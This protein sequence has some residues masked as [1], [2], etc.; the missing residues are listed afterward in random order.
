[1]GVQNRFWFAELPPQLCTTSTF[2]LF[3]P[4]HFFWF[5]LLFLPLIELFARWKTKATAVVWVFLI[6][7]EKTCLKLFSAEI[8]N[9]L[10]FNISIFL[11]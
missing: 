2:F 5:N 8:A 3:S 6:S 1:M 9:S 11:Y 10:K 7:N 4:F